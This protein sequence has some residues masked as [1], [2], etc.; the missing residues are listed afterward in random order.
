V[1]PTT[2]HPLRYVPLEIGPG[3]PTADGYGH[4]PCI[5]PYFENDGRRVNTVEGLQLGHVIR[6][7]DPP[8]GSYVSATSAQASLARLRYAEPPRVSRAVPAVLLPLSLITVRQPKVGVRAASRYP[9]S[10]MARH[11]PAL[12]GLATSVLAN[13]AAHRGDS[14][15]PA[16]ALEA[17]V[18]VLRADLV[19][20]VG[21]AGVEGLLARAIDLAR[22]E[23][24]GLQLDLGHAAS[25]GGDVRLALQRVPPDRAG[26][27]ASAVL[28]NLLELLVGFLGTDLGLSSARNAWPELVP[29]RLD[30][31]DPEGNG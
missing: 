13:A 18:D 10:S 6:Q 22:R 24:P 21:T 2:L 15:R 30:L 9:A 16:D 14:A 20:L 23:V 27:F 31:L 12:R 5:A 17:V 8:G 19:N 25:Q 1:Q 11:T 28:A 26:A 4:C 29:E 3:D 7:K